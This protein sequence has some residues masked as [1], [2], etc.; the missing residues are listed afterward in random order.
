MNND[1]LEIL[2]FGAGESWQAKRLATIGSVTACDTEIRAFDKESSGVNLI[3]ASIEHSPFKSHSFAL[4]FSNH[5][6]EHLPDV[7]KALAETRRIGTRDAIFAFTVPTRFWLLVAQVAMFGWKLADFARTWR[8][9]GVMAISQLFKLGVHGEHVTFSE[10]YN[11]FGTR[12]WRSL[13]E[14]NGFMILQSVPLLVYAPPELLLP[15]SRHLVRLGMCS[16]MLF[17]LKRANETSP[18]IC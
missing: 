4:V 5:V 12:S 6:L 17:V 9:E 13:L 1:R 14:A 2:E 3:Q 7:G 10:E 11:A 15:P 18:V 8:R 16:S